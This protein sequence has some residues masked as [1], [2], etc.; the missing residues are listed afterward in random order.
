MG[1][2][3]GKRF[4]FKITKEKTLLPTK[5]STLQNISSSNVMKKCLILYV[6][7][8]MFC[9]FLVY[10]RQ[11]YTNSVF[12]S[13]VCFGF[14]RLISLVS[15]SSRFV[16]FRFVFFLVVYVSVVSFWSSARSLYLV[17][18]LLRAA[19]MSADNVRG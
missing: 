8:E 17:N 4:V 1:V 13:L 12:R 19:G 15:E 11:P 10:P 7:F 9:D 16:L 2:T 18:K 5:L 6:N 3:L 14:G